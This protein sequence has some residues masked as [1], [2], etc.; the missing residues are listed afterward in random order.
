MG[1][2][3]YSEASISSSGASEETVSDAAFED[4]A[5]QIERQDALDL[6]AQW[7]DATRGS[8]I[9]RRQYRNLYQA[10]YTS[11]SLDSI[12]ETYGSWYAYQSATKKFYKDK[13]NASD[14]AK[15]KRLKTIRQEYELGLVPP[16]IFLETKRV[17]YCPVPTDQESPHEVKR[18]LLYYL[19]TERVS[20]E[21]I[22]ER[23]AKYTLL[24]HLK[25]QRLGLET[26]GMSDNRLLSICMGF[27]LDSGKPLGSFLG[28]IQNSHP[29]LKKEDL[30]HLIEELD[31][32]D[33]IYP[34][35][36]THH[37]GILMEV[38]NSSYRNPASVLWTGKKATKSY[39][40]W[41]R[42]R[43]RFSDI[44]NLLVSEDF[45]APEIDDRRPREVYGWS[46]EECIK[47]G[48]WL[49]DLVQ[50]SSGE[51]KINKAIIDRADILGVGLGS[52]R[53]IKRFG[54]MAKFYA[55]LGAVDA[56]VTGLFK[57]E[58]IE[59][60]AERLRELGER[61][62]RKPTEEDI[63]EAAR[64]KSF[65]SINVMTGQGYTL[66]QILDKAGW[67]DIYSWGLDDHENHGLMFMIANDGKPPTQLA[68]DYL[69]KSKRGPS[70]ALMRY[71]YDRGFSEFKQ[72]VI[73]LYEQEKNKVETGESNLAS[74]SRLSLLKL[75]DLKKPSSKKR[76][77][78]VLQ[79]KPVLNL[80]A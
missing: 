14:L 62:G 59:G 36:R 77:V 10:D 76:R 68:W 29:D 45:E 9:N 21:K 47:Y 37:L 65:P 8:L 78:A 20:D 66:R 75:P 43:R 42:T 13:R 6:G 26:S 79:E 69:S 30:D 27:T 28:C 71:K 19:G 2:V 16:E 46:R 23:Y 70:A 35:S 39:L 57:D 64:N 11:S 58:S 63:N 31:L 73:R 1:A 17:E 7:I 44:G 22:I 12:L 18:L 61:L 38:G 54:S 15:E 50:K 51:P 55:E 3:T 80:A 72:N 74:D 4:M 67:P 49:V 34:N 52:H 60:F 53:I 40:H 41:Q 56:K 33:D 5:Q 24:N 32:Y 25:Q 48:H